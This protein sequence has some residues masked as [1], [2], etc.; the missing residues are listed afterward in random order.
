MLTITNEQSVDVY[1][2]TVKDVHNFYANGILVHNCA[3]IAEPTKAYASVAQLYERWNESHGEIAL[4]SL[5]GVIVSNIANDEQYAKTA[6]YTLKMITYCIHKSHYVFPSLEDTAKAR[7]NA[8]VG[9]LGLAHLM[10][11]K[12]LKFD[13]LEGRNFAHELAETHYWH[14]VKAS[15]RISKEIGVA[16]WMHKTLWPE[17]WTPL[18]TYN[19]NVDS[20]VTVG[21]K[22]DW[23]G[24]SAEIVANGGIAH[25]VL[26]AHMPGESCLSSDTLVRMA[27]GTEKPLMDFLIATGVDVESLFLDYNPVQGGR[28]LELPS[29]MLVATPDGPKEVTMVWYNGHTNYITI[30]ME[31]GREVR[32]TYNHKFKVRRSDGSYGWKRASQLEEGDDVLDLCAIQSE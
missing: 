21:N 13:T 20:L 4:C 25:S 16:P 3:E 31:D 15:L 32:A 23:E 1:D 7:M 29:P 9:I 11:K 26:C 8:G 10:A 30:T 28:W 12:N 18:S 5:G 6:Y 2:I 19:R 14:L 27:D 24:L 22:R 17:G